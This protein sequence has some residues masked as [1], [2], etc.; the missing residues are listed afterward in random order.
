MASL[1]EA[2]I[3]HSYAE[4][5][6]VFSVDDSSDTLG[7]RNTDEE[8]VNRSKIAQRDLGDLSVVSSL[9][10]VKYGQWQKK[11][12]CLL[13]FRYQFQARHTHLLRFSE[14][15]IVIEFKSRPPASPQEDP[16]IVDYGP[17]KLESTGTDENRKR[18]LSATFSAKASFGP[19][20]IGPDFSVGRDSEY[21][22]HSAA[23][24]ETDDW[25]DRKHRRPNCVKCW[26]KEDQ[27]GE[28]GLPLELRV[29]VIVA[30]DGPMQ[31]T[32]DVR[33]GHLF[34]LLAWPWT[35]DDPVLLQPGISHGEFASFTSSLEFSDLTQ[36]DWRRLVTP[37]LQ[38]Q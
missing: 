3:R 33:A 34:H 13:A 29:A 7:Q 12:A 16:V 8:D 25:G 21:V 5:E 4:R 1:A 24:V 6:K 17:K 19:I 31:A 10:L 15:E 22:R 32:V 9:T 2:H 23:I 38:F 35:G 18:H 30:H 26:L 20:E 36:D 27:K 28:A 14:A 37:D 11:A